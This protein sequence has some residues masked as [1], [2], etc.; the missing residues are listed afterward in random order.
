MT[1]PLRAHHRRCHV[2]PPSSSSLAY[3]PKIQLRSHGNDTVAG[4][5]PTLPRH[6]PYTRGKGEGG[7]REEQ[8]QQPDTKAGVT[9][10]PT[11]FFLTSSM[12]V[13]SA[14]AAATGPPRSPDLPCLYRLAAAPA[15]VSATPTSASCS[16]AT[17]TA[18]ATTTTAPNAL[19]A[20]VR[21]R[22][23][24]QQHFNLPRVYRFE[25]GNNDCHGGSKFEYGS[26]NYCSNNAYYDLFSLLF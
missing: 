1:I 24:L 22:Q 21:R 8:R 3:Q 25:H 9:G 12:A 18:T 19:Q 7:R 26:G 11:P 15:T 20:Q 23:L 6:T 16:A 2:I 10:T 5:S 13:T 14:A 17:M 4:A